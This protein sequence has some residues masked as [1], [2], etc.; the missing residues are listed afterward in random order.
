MNIW[1]TSCPSPLF[2]TSATPEIPRWESPSILQLKWNP[3]LQGGEERAEEEAQRRNNMWSQFT[4]QYEET[5][6]AQIHWKVSVFLYQLLFKVEVGDFV[7]E[8]KATSFPVDIGNLRKK[9]RVHWLGFQ[10]SLL[11]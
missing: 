9:Y 1:K 3:G 4:S 5:H 7:G 8:I 10:M 6:Q 11:F 2:L